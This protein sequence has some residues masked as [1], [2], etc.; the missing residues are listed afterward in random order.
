MNVAKLAGEIE[1]L[2][3][4]AFERDG[5][6]EP[7]EEAVDSKMEELLAP[8][9]DLDLAYPKGNDSIETLKVYRKAVGEEMWPSL[10]GNP[11]VMS[12]AEKHKTQLLVDA[13]KASVKLI[14]AWAGEGFTNDHMTVILRTGV[15]E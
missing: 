11:S 8:L 14:Q 7:P 6:K 12:F 13:T 1:T 15:H 9:R 5:L 4:Q 3:S 10:A 2:F